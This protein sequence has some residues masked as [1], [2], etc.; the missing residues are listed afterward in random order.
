M[1][2]FIVRK[3]LILFDLLEKH[4]CIWYA[5][6]KKRYEYYYVWKVNPYDMFKVKK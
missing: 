4:R 5:C 1:K 3:F 2:L 6:G